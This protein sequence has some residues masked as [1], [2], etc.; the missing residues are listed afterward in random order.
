MHRDLLHNPARQPVCFVNQALRF[1]RQI[2][3]A[4]QG[5][6]KSRLNHRRALVS[7]MR[8]DVMREPYDLQPMRPLQDMN[9]G[10]LINGNP[11]IIRSH[12][13]IWPVEYHGVALRK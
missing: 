11:P 8:M 7:I 4:I 6:D 1:S 10:Q 9:S 2:N 3:D 5:I 13:L 12:E